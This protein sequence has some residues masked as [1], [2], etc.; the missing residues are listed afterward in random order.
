MD[1]LKSARA[2]VLKPLRKLFQFSPPPQEPAVPEGLRVYAIGDIHG[3]LDLLAAL[4]EAIEQDDRH[5]GDARSTVIMLGD[6]ID[7]GP[8]SAGVIRFARDWQS[9]RAVRILCGNHEEML[10]SGLERVEVLR[11]FLRHGG[12]E[13]I[14][15]YGL[16]EETYRLA[17]LEEVQDLMLKIIPRTDLAFINSFEDRILIGD[18]LFVHAGILPDVE[19]ER[20]RLHD[21]RWIREP[22]LSY[23]GRHS[24]M[25]VH[26]HT[27]TQEV[28]HLDNRIG[29]DTGAYLHG[30]LT[31]LV[32]E[33]T[34]RRFIAA[35]RTDGG[36]VTISTI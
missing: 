22:F 12:R 5:E 7:R 32:L 26:G 17:T 4:A 8:E 21:L 11:H 33:G 1:R 29:I 27:I 20:Q 34:R 14:L 36:P 18:Y 28:T 31:A 2:V 35:S 24:H 25:V 23:E 19:P 16:D 13:T 10:L 6:L 3:R 15:S 30:K 9:R